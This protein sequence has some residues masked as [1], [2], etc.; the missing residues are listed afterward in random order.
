MT[1]LIFIVI[2]YYINIKSIVFIISFI[3]TIDIRTVNV[4]IVLVEFPDFTSEILTFD[5][6]TL[7]L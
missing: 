6:S 2:I 7:G 4:V 5:E 3:I 1:I